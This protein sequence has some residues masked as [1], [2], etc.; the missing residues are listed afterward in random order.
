[1]STAAE[2]AP[3]VGP[4]GWIAWGAS[5]LRAIGPYAALELL[6]PGG[7]LIALLLWLYRRR[8]RASIG[9]TRRATATAAG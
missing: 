9:A 3:L 4:T 1:M 6:L 5:L 8:D 2:A 7:S